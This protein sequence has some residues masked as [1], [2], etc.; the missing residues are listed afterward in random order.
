[1]SY[2]LCWLHNFQPDKGLHNPTE[3]EQKYKFYINIKL[4]ITKL[5][6]VAPLIPDPS[7]ANS[8]TMHSRLACQD[9]NLCIGLFVWSGKTAKPFKQMKGF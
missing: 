9:R 2:H 6:G 8:I 7:F 3:S 5:D 1:M 4:T